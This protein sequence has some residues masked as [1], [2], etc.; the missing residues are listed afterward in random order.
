MSIKAM[1]SGAHV[2]CEKPMAVSSEGAKKMTAVSRETGKV[3]M[4]GVQRRFGAEAQYLKEYIESGGLGNIYRARA[5]WVRRRG[6]PGLGGWFTTKELSGGGAL[7]DI[8]VHVLDLALWLMGFPSPTDVCASVGARFGNRN[9][10]GRPAPHR[11][12]GTGGTF[13]VDDF[14]FAHVNFAGG[15]SLCLETSWAGYIKKDTVAIELWGDDGGAR[16]FPL[17]IFKDHLDQPI[18]ILPT[19]ANTNLHT[20]S[21][22]HFVNVLQGREELVS[23]P[24][25]GVKALELIEMIYHSAGLAGPEAA[26]RD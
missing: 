15:S 25:E 2:H 10:G 22:R 7:I 16:L 6:I 9:R 24:E 3:L 17:E 4:V 13:D 5:V 1:R 11:K 21:V 8:G 23:L 19:L 18:D 14:A 20:L 12:A 26:K